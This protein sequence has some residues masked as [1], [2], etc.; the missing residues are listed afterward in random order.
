[1]EFKVLFW[2]VWLENQIHGVHNSGLLL[3]EL[4]KIIQAH[5]P[6]YIG[7]NEVLQ[8]VGDTSPFVFSHLETHGYTY[9]HFAPAS[10]L[11]DE[12]VIGPGFVSKHKPKSHVD[13]IISGDTPAA[14]RGYT[15]H[16][17]KAITASFLLENS[18]LCNVVVAHAM[19]LRSYTLKDH[20]QATKTLDALLRKKEYSRNTIIGGDFNEPLTMPFSYRRKTRDILNIRSGNLANPTWRHGGSRLTPIRANL[21]QLY[22]PKDG[23]I[24]LSSFEIIQSTVS[25]HKPLMATFRI[26]RSVK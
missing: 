11:T 6:D 1:M 14:R 16:K 9:N 25:D 17:V 8:H 18:E 20:F 4:T 19:Y 15:G 3:N 21:D 23:P 26:G 10:P 22:W 5:Q 13:T 12:W 24:E 7:L 2:N